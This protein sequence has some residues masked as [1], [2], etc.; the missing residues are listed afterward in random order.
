MSFY[1]PVGP[2]KADGATELPLQPR[3]SGGPTMKIGTPTP[4]DKIKTFGGDPPYHIQE[5]PDSPEIERAEQATFMHR[6]KMKTTTAWNHLTQMGRGT[7]VEDSLHN[8]WR[9]LSAKMTSGRGGWSELSYVAESISFDSP[10]D[11]Y[12]INPVELGVNILKHPRYYWAL[13]PT[14]FDNTTY[15]T[16]GEVTVTARD[17]KE[18]LIRA[19]QN[20]M[21][22]PFF[23]TESKMS[24][25][26]Q[27]II[28]GR[29]KNGHIDMFVPVAGA[30]YTKKIDDPVKWNG[31]FDDLPAGNYDQAIVSVPC[32]LSKPNDIV[33]IAIAATR[34]MISK[35]WRQEDTPY[36]VGFEI[37]WTQYYFAPVYE[38]PG[39]Y[40]ES[41]FGIVPDYFLSPSQ[42]GSNTIFDAMAQINPQCYSLNRQPGGAGQVNISWL[43]MADECEYQRTWFKVVRRWRGCPIGTW[44]HD[45]YKQIG[46]MGPQTADDFNVALP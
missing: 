1:L 5:L 11:E 12:R 15:A 7:F 45:L 46:E 41:P 2:D 14:Q 35:L 36:T 10:P 44:D 6:V 23:P 8:V 29:I 33:A 4:A 43:R 18:T 30:D 38:N 9:I 32:D 20:Y 17:I 39:G 25:L 3:G 31:Y 24:G 19:I 16:V 22:S 37:V 21:E 34:E 13:S 26:L 27:E 28:L 40:R 42:D